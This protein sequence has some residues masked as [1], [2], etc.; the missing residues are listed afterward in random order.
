LISGSIT[1]YLIG[2]F[3]AWSR[4][5][6]LLSQ[7]FPDWTNTDMSL[8][9]SLCVCLTCVG[10]MCAGPV[11]RR[12]GYCRT[13]RLGAGMMLAGLL[14]F[15]GIEFLSGGIAKLVM[16]GTYGVLAALGCGLIYNAGLSGTTRWFTEKS[17]L[18]TGLLLTCYGLS[19]ISL[20]SLMVLAAERW[21]FFLAFRLLALLM[22]A[23]IFALSGQFRPAPESAS[24]AV[25][26]EG[27]TTG[28]MLRTPAFWLSAMWM[29]V[30]TGQGLMV[31]NSAADIA[32]GF[33]VAASLGLIVSLFNG[34][35]RLGGGALIDRTW[36]APVI[37]TL[38]AVCGAALLLTANAGRGAVF[39]FLG[40]IFTG[41]SYG[42]SLAIN[43]TMI[44]KVFGAR[45][46]SQN[47]GVSNLSGPLASFLGPL[48]A[49]IAQD[50]AG[51][52]YASTYWLMLLFDAVALVVCV[53]MLLSIRRLRAGKRE[54]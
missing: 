37:D 20:G 36:L 19:A 41:V 7:H 13:I 32:R 26:G 49:G 17:G 39:M 12:L 1:M 33:G 22:F 21:G 3:Y 38:L 35:S 30:I 52:G 8:N 25:G 5:R 11:L 18:V 51:G 4:Y 27:F 23:V 15:T 2:V 46:Y 47:F 16:Y 28:E 50:R 48:A 34:V 9:F 42:G 31:M 54:D 29:V 24:A 6:L 14:L 40:L 44:K 45:H 53:G 10:A 43:A